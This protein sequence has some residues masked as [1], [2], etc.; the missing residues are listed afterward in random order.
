[1]TI[2]LVTILVALIALFIAMTAG[3][4]IAQRRPRADRRRRRRRAHLPVGGKAADR[5]SG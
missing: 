2:V 3:Q 1:M 5:R 4:M